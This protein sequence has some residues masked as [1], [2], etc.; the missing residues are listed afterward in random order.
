[1]LPLKGIFDSRRLQDG[2][3]RHLGYTWPYTLT[4]V[5]MEVDG[6]RFPIQAIPSANSRG[7]AA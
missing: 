5:V 6:S 3:S 7:Y 1:M 2:H 4:S